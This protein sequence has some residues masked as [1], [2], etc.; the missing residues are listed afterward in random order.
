MVR[1]LEFAA[2]QNPLSS[3]GTVAVSAGSGEA[4]IFI[5]PGFRFRVVSAL[6]TNFHLPKSTLLMLGFCVCRKGARFG[7][8]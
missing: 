7:G 2:L 1:T 5:Y 3:D 6:L 8:L 4:D